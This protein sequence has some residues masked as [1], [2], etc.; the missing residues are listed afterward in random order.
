LARKF[1]RFFVWSERKNRRRQ[2][3]ILQVEGLRLLATGGTASAAATLIERLGGEVVEVA[4]LIELEG[5]NGRA[6]LNRPFYSLVSIE[7]DE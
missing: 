1:L 4:C 6:H 5:L 3:L 2:K 7:V